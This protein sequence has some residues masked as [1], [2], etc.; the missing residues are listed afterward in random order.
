MLRTYSQDL[1]DLFVKSVKGDKKAFTALL[2]TEKHPELAALSNAI[3][4]DEQAV[5][6]LRARAKDLWV[7]FEAM[8]HNEPALKKL[9]MQEDKF[10]I[11]FVLAC[12]DRIEG[13]VWLEKNN[14][15][16]FLPICETI[17]SMLKTASKIG[18][19][20]W[21]YNGSIRKLH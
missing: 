4:G 10:D 8:D 5:M 18:A 15:T 17:A 3:R 2:T 6:W 19:W 16:Q 7:L 14:Y 12:R 11:S 13:K 20:D 21:L 1:L 9:Q